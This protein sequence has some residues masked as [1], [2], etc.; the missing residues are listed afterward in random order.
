[1]NIVAVKTITDVTPSVAIDY[2]LR[3]GFTSLQLDGA[4]SDAGQAMALGGLTN[5]VSNLELTAAY[6]GIANGGSYYKPKLYSKIVDNEGNVILDNTVEE[7][8]QV[9]SECM[10]SDR[11]YERCS[12]RCRRNVQ[13]SQDQQYDYCR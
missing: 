1:M 3:F 8:T 12:H 13:C 6:A 11:L 10:A 5:G 2:L 4:N 7:P 9:I